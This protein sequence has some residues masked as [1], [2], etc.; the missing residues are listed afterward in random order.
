M[1]MT[2]R[3]QCT[4]CR[5]GASNLG[6]SSSEFRSVPRLDCDWVSHVD[7][8]AW[9]IHGRLVGGDLEAQE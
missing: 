5:A 4:V 8:H 6:I 7:F 9:D 2:I 1:T 3:L